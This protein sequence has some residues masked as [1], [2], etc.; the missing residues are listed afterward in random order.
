MR[1][2]VDEN[3]TERRDSGNRS[4]GKLIRGCVGG[5]NKGENGDIGDKELFC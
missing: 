5:T 4:L 1:I 2:S 3:K